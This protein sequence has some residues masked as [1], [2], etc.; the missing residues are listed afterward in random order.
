MP[1]FYHSHGAPNPRRIAILIAEKGLQDQIETVQVPIAEAAH[2]KPEYRKIAPNS[3]IPALGLDDGSVILETSAI[4]RYID[5]S[6]APTSFVGT[7]PADVAAVEMWSRRAEYEVMMPY[8]MLFR[9]T[10]PGM[11]HLESQFPEYG[12]SQ[13][14]VVEKTL[15]YFDRHLEDREYLATD[16]Y[17]WADITL[18]CIL[19][20]FPRVTEVKLDGFPSIQG[21]MERI[22]NR[23]ASKTM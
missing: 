4:A 14:I 10:H 9:H 1:K 18:Y 15:K 3:R 5:T 23:P 2:K 12:N 20:F 17:S 19:A 16:F 11:A 21:Y 8:A 6:H 13:G 7:N 22:T